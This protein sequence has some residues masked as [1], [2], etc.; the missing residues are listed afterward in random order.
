M[1][2]VAVV[3]VGAEFYHASGKLAK[4]VRRTLDEI[5]ATMVGKYNQIGSLF[6]RLS[7]AVAD[8]GEGFLAE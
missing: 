7:N 2:A 3:D 1:R 4:F 5:G 8:A 6:T